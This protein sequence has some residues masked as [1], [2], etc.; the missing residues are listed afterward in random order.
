MLTWGDPWASEASQGEGTG[1]DMTARVQSRD[2]HGKKQPALTGYCLS[3]MAHKHVH[4]YT[5][6][7]AH[8]C[9]YTHIHTCKRTPAHTQKIFI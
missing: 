7:H 8:T 1:R 6:L 2:P 9:A 3:Y 5:H 4:T